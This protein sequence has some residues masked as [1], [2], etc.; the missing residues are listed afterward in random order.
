VVQGGRFTSL[1]AVAVCGEVAAVVRRRG[2]AKFVDGLTSA[3]GRAI[4]PLRD[5][6]GLIDEAHPRMVS[7]TPGEATHVPSA[8]S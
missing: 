7:N 6:V 3:K 8:A 4:N 2:A 1:G 5:A